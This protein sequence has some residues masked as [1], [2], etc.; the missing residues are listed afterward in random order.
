MGDDRVNFSGK[1]G[2]QQRVLPSYRTAF[3]DALAESCDGGLSV[4]AGRPKNMESIQFTYELDVGEY[5][6]AKNRHFSNSD[7]PYYLLW[8]DGLIPWLELWDPDVLVVEANPRYLSTRRAVN[9]MHTRS[10]PVIGWGLGA[11]PI[12]KPASMLGKITNSWQ[13]NARIKFLR[14][15]DALIAYSSLGAEQ[16]RSLS[17]PQ[18]PVFVAANAVTR[19]PIGEPPERAAHSH[20]LNV[21][22]VGRLQHRKR[23][24]NLLR[25]CAQLPGGLQPNLRIIGDGPAR[26]DFQELA[27]SVYPF[28]EF[29]GEIHRPELDEFFL[30]AD[31]FVLPGTGGLAV[32]EAMSHGLPVIVAKGDGTQEDLVKPTNGWL[33]PGGDVQALIDALADALSDPERL[34]KMGANSFKIVRDEVNVDQMVKVFVKAFSAVKQMEISPT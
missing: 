30:G 29:L 28:A 20:P 1:V 2:I 22:F 3:F 15:M 4:F 34:T 16:Y 33:I 18:Q 17:L 27:R 13:Q 6:F 31:L 7:S 14:K 21:L 8:Q 26:K 11:P 32:Q 19:G 10:R 5:Y 9:W 23:I 24:D 25:A 12:E